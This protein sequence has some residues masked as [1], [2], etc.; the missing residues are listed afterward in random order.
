LAKLTQSGALVALGTDSRASN[1]DLNLLG[2]MREI[3]TRDIVDP[4]R[5]VEMATING[6]KALGCDRETGS[7]G[8]GKR[9]D[10]A[11]VRLSGATGDDLYELLFDDRSSIE[12]TIRRGEVA[13]GRALF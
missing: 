1:P 3:F 9:A 5:I 4:Q 12:T 7:I 6:A 8:S 13:A 10:L 2:E 11:I